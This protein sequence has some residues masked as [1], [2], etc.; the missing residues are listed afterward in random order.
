LVLA[1]PTYGLAAD[2]ADQADNVGRVDTPRYR[3][4]ARVICLDSSYNVLLLRWRDPFDGSHLWEPPGGGIEPGESPFQTAGRE[5]AEETGLS[6]AAV[7]DRSVSVDRDV[8]FNGKRFTGPEHFF[9][10]RFDSVRPEVDRAGLLADEQVN[11][12]EY[13]WV[14]WS[15]LDTLPD[16]LQPPR[17]LEMLAE[18]VPDGPWSQ[19]QSEERSDVGMDVQEQVDATDRED[20]ARG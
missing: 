1:P 18:L 4:A 6:P 2:F 11:L 10:A 8:R 5:L 12:Q 9:L 14:S 20:V 3:P 19:K 17:L 15:A 7:L 13:A 16:R